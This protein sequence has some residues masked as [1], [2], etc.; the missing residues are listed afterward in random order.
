MRENI[1]NLKLYTTY[2]TTSLNRYQIV[3]VITRFLCIFILLGSVDTVIEWRCPNYVHLYQTMLNDLLFQFNVEGAS[4]IA[5]EVLSMLI[6][7]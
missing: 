5:L 4:F 6:L 2:F 1:L 3:R 7:K